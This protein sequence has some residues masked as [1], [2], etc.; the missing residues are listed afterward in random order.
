MR[1]DGCKL[2][3]ETVEDDDKKEVGERDPSHVWLT[4]GLENQG[5]TVDALCRQ[6]LLE[7]GVGEENAA[8]GDQLRDR[9]Q[10]LEPDEDV[11]G[12]G[13]NTHEREQRDGQSDEDAVDRDTALRALEQEAR[14]VAVLCDSEEITRARIQ[15]SIARRSCGGQN[16]R[17]DDVGEHWNHSVLAGNDPRRLLRTG[18]TLRGQLRVAGA[19]ADTN[20]ERA[21]DVEEE[22]TPEDTADSL[23]NVLPWVL[24]PGLVTC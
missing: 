16:D 9:S 1:I 6:R 19:D 11:V 21:E 13:R 4:R 17:V 8:P 7:T 20:D 3:L 14:S 22:D 18:S 12:A 5:V 24:Q 23:G 15:E 10:V 2:T